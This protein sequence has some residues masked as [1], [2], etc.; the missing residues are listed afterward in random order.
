MDTVVSTVNQVAALLG[1]EP[2]RVR[3]WMRRQDWRTPAEKGSPW[4]LTPAQVDAITAKFTSATD[5]APT[6]AVVPET[7]ADSAQG[8]LPD[9]SVG[10]LLAMNGKV[11]AELRSRGLVRTNN[12]PIGDLA[13]YCAAV[14][15]DGLLAPN[16]ERS[17]DLTAADGRKVQ[18]KVRLV[19]PTTVASALFS[20][21]RF[22]DFDVC[23]FIMID[24]AAQSVLA[25]REWTADEV[26]EF[27]HHRVHTNGTVV[28]LG[29]VRSSNPLGVDKTRVF[30]ATWRDLLSQRL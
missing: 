23:V 16:S 21:I 3:T 15:Y 7:S 19:Y 22:F 5:P 8:P 1:V 30:N 11:L 17:Y 14:V 29:Q 27:G 25:A 9:L 24:H 12:A 6:P 20:S 13:E 4:A 10:E 28:R 2:Q 26:R 18:V